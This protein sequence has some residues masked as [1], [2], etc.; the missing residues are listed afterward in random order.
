MSR[1]IRVAAAGDVRWD[2]TNR[3]EFELAFRR[4]QDDVKAILLARDF[5][6]SSSDGASMRHA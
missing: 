6:S 4:A 1:P 3:E 2:E 5:F